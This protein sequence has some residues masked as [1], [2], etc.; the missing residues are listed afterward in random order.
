[1]RKKSLLT[2]TTLI[3]MTFIFTS[4]ALAYSF[5]GHTWS[6]TNGNTYNVSVKYATTNTTYRAAF[7][8]AVSDWNSSQSKIKFNLS[9]LNVSSLNKVGTQDVDNPSLYGVCITYPISG[10]AKISYFTADLNIGNPNV[11]NYSKTRRS[12]AGH[13]LGHALGLD[14]VSVLVTAIMNSS[15]DRETVYTPQTDDINGVNALY[16][17]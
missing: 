4:S 17:L 2:V 15:R 8:S 16:P 13:E 6:K 3:L 5:T 12:T 10:T 11:V 1:M 7:D 14:H 9:A